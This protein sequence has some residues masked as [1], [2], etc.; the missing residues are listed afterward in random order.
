MLDQTWSS[1]GQIMLTPAAH[2]STSICPAP[3]S[4]GLILTRGLVDASLC[5][6]AIVAESHPSRNFLS[7]SPG[8]VPFRLQPLIGA[9]CENPCATNVL[10]RSNSSHNDCR[11]LRMTRSVLRNKR[12]NAVLRRTMQVLGASIGLNSK[13]APCVREYTTDAVLTE[14]KL[15]TL[16]FSAL[17]PAL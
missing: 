17:R 3:A 4:T 12:S 16:L 6:C 1:P 5:H 2:S 14:E 10:T 7:S 13:S 8:P 9:C 15:K 11:G